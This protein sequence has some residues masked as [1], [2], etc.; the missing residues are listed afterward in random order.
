MAPQCLGSVQGHPQGTAHGAASHPDRFGSVSLWVSAVARE[1]FSVAAASGAV[2]AVLA[3]LC[4][5]AV[6]GAICA[7]TEP[8]T[9]MEDTH[10]EGR[11]GQRTCPEEPQSLV[12][13]VAATAALSPGH[14]R[15]QK[16]NVALDSLSLSMW[17][18]ASTHS[19]TSSHA[20]GLKFI[21]YSL[22]LHS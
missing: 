12:E 9:C 7:S 4:T 16:L 11:A 5:R 17:G 3:V 6:S 18:I 1:G 2:L 10:C 22:N 19:V 15:I 21:L 8:V 13:V 20:P 14:G